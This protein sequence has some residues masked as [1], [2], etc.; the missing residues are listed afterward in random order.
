MQNSSDDNP[1]SANTEGRQFLFLMSSARRNGNAEILTRHAT[2]NFPPRWQQRWLHHLDLPL[3]P[4]LDI[5]HDGDDHYEPPSGNLRILAEAT[6][7]ATDV[8][9]VAPVY[10]YNL[11]AAAK[12]YLDHW[13]GW[14]RVPCLDFRARMEG[15][16]MWS[17]TVVSDPDRSYAEPLLKSLQLCADYMQMIWAGSVVGYGNCP[18]DVL[19]DSVSLSAAEMLFQPRR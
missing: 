14:L 5:R 10:W 3:P 9:F 2:K 15:K 13:S 4:F 18:G 17:I 11:P 12:V 16:R 19:N 7:I 8:V 6:L 1:G